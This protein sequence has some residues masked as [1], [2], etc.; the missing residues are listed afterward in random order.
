MP[1]A[2]CGIEAKIRKRTLLAGFPRPI[3]ANAETRFN[4]VEFGRRGV[5]PSHQRCRGRVALT[6]RQDASGDAERLGLGTKRILSV[7]LAGGL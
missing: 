5:I 2:V 6:V 3:G 4:M 7:V 1:R